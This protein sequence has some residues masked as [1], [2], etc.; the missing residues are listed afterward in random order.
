MRVL[1]VCNGYF[2]NNSW[3]HD[4]W[5]G[6]C[7]LGT[8]CVQSSR[9]RMPHTFSLCDRRDRVAENKEGSTSRALME[10]WGRQLLI[11]VAMS[12]EGN[13]RQVWE[14]QVWRGFWGL[15][16][17]I[18][19]AEQELCG[20][21][22]AFT[23]TSAALAVVTNLSDLVENHCS[24]GFLMGHQ[25]STDYRLVTTGL[26]ESSSSPIPPLGLQPLWGSMY[27]SLFHDSFATI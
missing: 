24:K 27:P 13:W 17:G 15:R 5:E 7:V 16:G 26:E 21:H 6:R 3:Q 22:R 19:R 25:W 20:Q 23:L 2:R 18:R 12:S 4:K 8:E 10:G 11:G 1:C 14:T 9:D